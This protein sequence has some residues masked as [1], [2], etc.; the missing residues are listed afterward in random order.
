MNLTTRRRLPFYAA[1]AGVA[2]VVAVLLIREESPAPVRVAYAPVTRGAVEREVLTSGT[3]EPAKIVNAGTQVSGTI[4]TLDVD[5]NSR[6]KAGQVI[7]RL[8][9][10]VYD[11]RVVE[12][13]A[14]AGA[15]RSR[16]GRWAGSRPT[17]RG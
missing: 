3:L 11:S 6:V 12:A 14:R 13:Q 4:Q 7:A 5:F 17:T 10:S 8:D 15:G 16:A 9:P 2:I 1:T